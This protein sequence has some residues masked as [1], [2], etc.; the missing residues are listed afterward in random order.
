MGYLIARRSQ[1]PPR[2]TVLSVALNGGFGLAIVA[3]KILID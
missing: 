2:A 1:L 3:L